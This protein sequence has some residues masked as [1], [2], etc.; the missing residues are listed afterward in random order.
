M[1]LLVIAGLIVGFLNVTDKESSA[2]L[3]ATVAL[4]IT[5]TAEDQLRLITFLNMGDA[6]ANVVKQI[7]VFVAPAAI[8]VA[9]KSLHSL[10]KD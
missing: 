9:L 5:S 7:G 2:F 8:I 3:V 10:A 1:F 6:F 4:L